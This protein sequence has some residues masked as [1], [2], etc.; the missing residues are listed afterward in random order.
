MIDE[1]IEIH[2]LFDKYHLK[3]QRRLKIYNQIYNK[4]IYK[5]KS[6]SNRGDSI[7]STYFI[8]PEYQFGVPLYNQTTCIAYAIIKL[9][10]I[11]FDVN[12]T[13]PNFIYISW[14]KFINT[15]RFQ[16]QAI[17]NH[18]NFHNNHILVTQPRKIKTFFRNLN[19][20]LIDESDR[21][22]KANIH[23]DILDNIKNRAELLTKF[24]P[25]SVQ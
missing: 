24:N 18:R 19:D 25:G 1:G 4:I 7:F 21:A 23:F 2:Q 22:D 17:D 13:H 15:H 11:G 5:I 12:Y 16:I 9:R 14:H 8:V 3:Q 10:K 20:Q 6:I